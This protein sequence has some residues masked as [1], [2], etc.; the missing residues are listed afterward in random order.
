M[1]VAE[2]AIR[3]VRDVLIM[4]KQLFDVER[5]LASTREGLIALTQAVGLLNA[6]V[7]KLEGIIEGVAMAS[8]QMQPRRLA[9]PD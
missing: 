9:P 5:G 4:H 7:V 1:S 2:S 3:A 8:P 6:R